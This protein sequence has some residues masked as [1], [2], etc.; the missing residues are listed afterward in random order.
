[1]AILTANTTLMYKTTDLAEYAKLVDITDYP[2]MGSA[3]SKIETTTLSATKFKTNILGLMDAPDL[4]FG[5]N[6]DK[7]VLATI[8][9]LLGST[10][11]FQL[12][13]GTAGAD[14]IFTW[15]GGV[16]AY[17]MGGAVDELRTMSVVCSAET[18]I[19]VS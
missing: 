17:T 1:M 15:Q 18:E 14:G 6:Y 8:D 16:Q 2:D 19:V 7:T 9:A 4:T 13:F 10:V 11:F 12:Q 3:P 5:A